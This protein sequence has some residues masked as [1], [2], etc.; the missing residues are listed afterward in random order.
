MLNSNIVQIANSDDPKAEIL[1]RVGD[2]SQHVVL[3][4]RVLVAT[5]PGRSKS[6]GGILYTDNKIAESRFQSKVH[7][8]LAIGPL[9]FKYEGPFKLQ[10][11]ERPPVS[12]GDWVM[13]N[14][15]NTREFFLGGPEKEGGLSCRQIPSSLIEA[16]VGDPDT[17]Y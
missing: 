8:V 5:Y 1:A 9:A 14:P 6:P 7:L 15:S 3:G 4:D 13:I 17:I 10:E 2:I 11:D 12:V 16:V